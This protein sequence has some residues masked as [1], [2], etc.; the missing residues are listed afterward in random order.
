MV[1]SAIAFI[2]QSN[3]VLTS[4]PK[5]TICCEQNYSWKSHKSLTSCS[6]LPNLPVLFLFSPLAVEQI[7]VLWQNNWSSCWCSGA[8]WC[9]ITSV[10]K[11]WGHICTVRDS[12]HQRPRELTMAARRRL[13]LVP[14]ACI[15]WM[16]WRPCGG[17]VMLSKLFSLS[18]SLELPPLS[19]SH[20]CWT[21]VI[22]E[23]NSHLLQL[24]G[25]W[26]SI[27]VFVSVLVYLS[28]LKWS[29]IYKYL[30]VWLFDF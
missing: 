8:V 19:F 21:S 3:Q 2:L 16:S 22:M 4:T 7:A 18:S 24:Y 29:H 15:H 23:V 14:G 30:W 10:L 28:L 27:P 25:I 17:I 1:Y 13:P 12:P 11:L 9:E 6:I 20:V 26:H 5:V